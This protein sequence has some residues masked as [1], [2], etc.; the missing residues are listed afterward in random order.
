MKLFLQQKEFV[1]ISNHRFAHFFDD[2]A[3]LKCEDMKKSYNNFNITVVDDGT[4]TN[5]TRLGAVKD[6]QYAI[7]KLNIT[8]DVFVMAGD[9]LL[10]FSLSGFVSYAKEK[11]TSCVM[12]H[13]ELELK[14]QQ[15]TAIIT[16]DED[17]CITSYEEK[18]LEPKGCYAV[19]PFY[20]YYAEIFKGGFIS[21]VKKIT[22]TVLSRKIYAVNFREL[23]G[24]LGV[25]P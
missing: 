21:P 22:T 7:D 12:C 13:E 2:W 25:C 15:K 17:G 6:I 11:G 24:V 5:E 19:P 4:E 3:A 23:L 16:M 14:K 1:V 8:D 9:N 20:I 10:D 18:P